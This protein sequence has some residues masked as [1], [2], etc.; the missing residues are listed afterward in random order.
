MELNREQ[1]EKAMDWLDCLVGYSSNDSEMA[2]RTYQLLGILYDTCEELTEKNAIQTI[3][4]IE[5]DKQVQ[6]LT[7]DNER[8]RAESENESI[9]WRQHF[10]SIYQTAKETVKAGTVRKMQE[11]L[12]EAFNSH[13]YNC[14]D[15]IKSKVDQIAKEMLE[16]VD[17]KA[18]RAA[19][20]G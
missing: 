18:I 17:T 6:R 10:E 8:L 9:L 15:C 20:R 16:G 3:T 12:N 14:R 5:L 2:M 13:S 11:R 19:L 1:V 7:E 4:A